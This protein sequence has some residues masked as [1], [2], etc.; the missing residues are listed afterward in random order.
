LTGQR[1]VGVSIGAFV[2]L[3]YTLQILGLSSQYMASATISQ[4]HDRMVA[5]DIYRRIGEL[6]ADFDRNEP[7]EVDVYG[8]KDFS[9]IYASGWSSAMQGS[10]FAW[11]Q[12][13][14]PRMLVYMRLMGYQPLP[15]IS[16]SEQRK[17]TPLFLEMPV[18]PAAGCVRKVGNRYL[19]RLSRDPDPAHAGTPP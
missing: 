2:V 17:M 6:T 11:D 14:L 19:V 18:W 3:V 5:A 10:F 4:A 15:L 9:T 12:G 8:H 1:T 13:D 7:V 16:K